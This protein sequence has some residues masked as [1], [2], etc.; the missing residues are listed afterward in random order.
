MIISSQVSFWG[1]VVSTWAGDD[2]CGNDNKVGTFVDVS[3]NKDRAKEHGF[4][5]GSVVVG[6]M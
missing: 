3:G 4:I 2:A 6:C 5:D 1:V